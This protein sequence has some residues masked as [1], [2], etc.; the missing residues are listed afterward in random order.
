MPRQ[1]SNP[2]KSYQKLTPSE[3]LSSLS[4]NLHFKTSPKVEERIPIVQ[5]AI[6]ELPLNPPEKDDG[7]KL[8]WLG[9]ASI[10]LLL[11]HMTND[12]TNKMEWI[13]ILFDPVFSKRCSPIKSIGPKRRTEIPCNVKD[14]PKVDFVFISHDHYD[15]LDK[16]TI[17][18]IEKY[19]PNAKYCV[20]N[21]L[22][23]ILIKFGVLSYKITELG[24]WRESVIPLSQVSHTSSK[25]D[26][27]P[28]IETVNPLDI[29][30]SSPTKA[31][32]SH[33]KNDVENDTPFS[34]SSFKTALSQTESENTMVPSP[35]APTS[36]SSSSNGLKIVC[37]PSQ[38]NSGR[39]LFG[40]NKTLWCT[41]WIELEL[42]NGKIWKCFF[43]GDTGYK[44]VQGGPTCPIFR[45]L[46]DRL[47]SPDLALLPIA[48]GSVLPYLQSLLPF[49]TFNSERLT[50][51]IHCSPFDAMTIHHELE[52]KISLPIH[53]ATWTTESGAKQMARD[54]R[55]AW[56]GDT[57]SLKW[58]DRFDD[59]HRATKIPQ[60]YTGFLINDIGSSI[61]FEVESGIETPVVVITAEDKP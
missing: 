37:C 21:G 16:D 18:D 36:R 3:I 53:W 38:H 46:K 11:P 29:G 15:H 51:A 13:G 40:K 59:E 34:P 61:Q 33:P 48:H 45:E 54:L 43:G 30:S 25:P 23:S 4:L 35:E 19:H 20:P 24:W 31:E 27:L 6:T 17:K 55:K 52:A 10:Y 26:L 1:Y 42:P 50:S 47:G 39:N 41:W 7:P 2:W 28:K 56:E 8:I 57:A 12:G 58:Y 60:A 44:S 9:H 49:I 5:N 32:D 22:K 14:L